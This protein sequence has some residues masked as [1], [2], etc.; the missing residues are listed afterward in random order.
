MFAKYG[1]SFL[2]VIGINAEIKAVCS[3]EIVTDDLKTHLLDLLIYTTDD[4]LINIEFHSSNLD[5]KN[6]ARYFKYAHETYRKYRK[7][8]KSIIILNEK[9]DEDYKLFEINKRQH[10]CF[11]LIS[12]KNYNAQN[13]ISSVKDKL[14][15]NQPI[16]K[17]DII[18]LTLIGFTNYQQTLEEILI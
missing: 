15:N 12:L 10:Y 2:E 9:I 18:Q 4:E 11:Q 1:L 17:K 3:T 6:L 14:I 13:I 8:V 7:E 5:E 16:S